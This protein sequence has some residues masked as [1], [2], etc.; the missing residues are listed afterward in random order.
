MVEKVLGDFNIKKFWIILPFEA[1]FNVNNKWLGHEV[2]YKQKTFNCWLQLLAMEQ[3]G[4]WK[5]KSA[6]T[7]CL[8]KGLFHDYICFHCQPAA[9]YSNDAK[10]VVIM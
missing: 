9:L 2:S 5:V 4:S 7:Q 8:N 10:L 6:I 1:N 3:Y